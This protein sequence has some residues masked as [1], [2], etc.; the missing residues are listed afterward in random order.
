MGLVAVL[1][2]IF[3]FVLIRRRHSRGRVG[4]STTEWPTTT[5]PAT[6]VGIPQPMSTPLVP[7]PHSGIF[8]GNPFTSEPHSIHQEEGS[9]S[10]VGGDP[11]VDQHVEALQ[12]EV[13]RLRARIHVS[14]PLK[15][16]LPTSGKMS[17]LQTGI[18]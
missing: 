4:L 11:M 8:E 6:Q 18:M 3:A 17:H 13:A 2:T 15:H 5:S 10:A 12:A 14:S 7:P 16:H 9:G 1:I